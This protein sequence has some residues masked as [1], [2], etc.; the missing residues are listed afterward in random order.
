MT[1]GD[2]V[3]LL[4]H[5][6][7]RRRAEAIIKNGPDVN[8]RE[9]GGF[10]TAGGFSTARVPHAC[11]SGQP[12]TMAHL[13]ALLYPNEGGPAVVEIE[14]P[15]SIVRIADLIDEV[16]FEPGYGLEELLAVWPA[17][18]KRIIIL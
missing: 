8:F 3:V 10:E 12:E 18:S 17:I 7:T 4:R 16:R 9:P 5:G 15:E 6:T 14:V 13:K 11:P 2:P 1:P